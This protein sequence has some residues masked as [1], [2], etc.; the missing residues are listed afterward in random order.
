MK[1]L[2]I[3]K[4][5]KHT[6]VNGK[7]IDFTEAMVAAIA[8]CY[9]PAKHEAPIVV[10]H[11]KTDDPA[12]GWARS[13]SFADGALIAA[14][15]QVDPAFAEL[16][17]AGRFKKISASFYE[18]DAT[19][20]PVP[21]QFYLRHIGF[22][23]ANPPAVKG[24]KS[25]SFADSDEG[26]VEFAD[27]APWRMRSLGTI[28]RNLREWVISK[29]TI[30]EA[31]RVLPGYLIEDIES[32]PEGNAVGAAFSETTETDML[33]KEQQ[34]A[35]AKLKADREALDR[36]TAEF[37]ER[38]KALKAA[39]R[40]AHT[41]GVAEFVTGL[42][43][44]GKLLPRDEAGLVAYMAGPNDAGVIEFGEGND[45]K[46]AAPADWLR[47]FLE[48][49]PKQVDY[50]ERAAAEDDA[51]GTVSFAAPPGYSVDPV[52]LE[53]HGKALAYQGQHP[54]TTYE[55]ALAAVQ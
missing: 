47:E 35:A 21:G 25:A 37:A 54:N 18:P 27:I 43:K 3:F 23:G 34:D 45:K 26:I 15:D 51:A 7:V 36:K 22:L 28:L 16:V 4:P 53:L 8:S 33:T 48:G 12:Y 24:L 6:A 1:A 5:G 42:V 10:G 46:T 29:N 55:A 50:Q 49:L 52:R 11:P 17:N 31:D 30:E 14:P 38:D 44:A 41:K 32:A 13:L 2:H 19:A 9:D 39:E 40:A 20:N